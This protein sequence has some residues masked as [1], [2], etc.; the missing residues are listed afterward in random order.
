MP[1][2]SDTDIGNFCKFFEEKFTE[3]EMRD[4]TSSRPSYGTSIQAESMM[5][6]VERPAPC[7]PNVRARIGFG[8]SL[9]PCA[10]AR[11]LFGLAELVAVIVIV[12][13]E[14]P[15]RAIRAIGIIISTLRTGR[16][17]VG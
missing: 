15:P 16:I 6:F 1:T 7:R 14:I 5:T 9:I 10:S 3:H 2:I 17:A 12:A 13:V 8:I 4:A 11:M